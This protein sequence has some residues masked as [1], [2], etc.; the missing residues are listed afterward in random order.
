MYESDPNSESNIRFS[1]YFQTSMLRFFIKES[2]E[3]SY[4]IKMHIACPHNNNN[5]NNNN[6]LLSVFR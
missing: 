4:G 2:N 6:M 1:I 3:Y 5:N